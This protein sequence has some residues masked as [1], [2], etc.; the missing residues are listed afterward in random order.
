MK[1]DHDWFDDEKSIFLISQFWRF[2]VISL[3]PDKHLRSR[4]SFISWFICKHDR[5]DKI[6]FLPSLVF[7]S[8]ISSSS[9]TPHPKKQTLQTSSL[10]FYF[11]FKSLKFIRFLWFTLLCRKYLRSAFDKNIEIEIQDRQDR[12]NQVRCR[13]CA[14]SIACSM[15]LVCFFCFFSIDL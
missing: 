8:Y 9:F 10:N 12:E 15:F 6:S 14:L 3:T 5:Q 4:V 11:G 13:C 1:P 7:L 2:W